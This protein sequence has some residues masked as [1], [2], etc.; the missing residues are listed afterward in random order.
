MQKN[1]EWRRMADWQALTALTQSR[2]LAVERVR[3]CDSG[4]AIEGDFEPP[5][6]ARLD[7][8]DQVFV[9]AFVRSHGSIKEMERIFGVSYPTIKARLNRIGAALDFVETDPGPSRAE[10]LDRL[11][12]GDITAA[13]AI[14][15]LERGGA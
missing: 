13:E 9:A 12:R 5:P 8:A 15:Q 3:L 11:E 1:A 14:A 2:P 4:I 6:L 7:P 10:I